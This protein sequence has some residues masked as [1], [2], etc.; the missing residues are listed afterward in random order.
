M[1]IHS[2]SLTAAGSQV[3]IPS[4]VLSSFLAW[5]C[6]REVKGQLLNGTTESLK[7]EENFEYFLSC[8]KDELHSGKEVQDH[9]QKKN[10]EEMLSLSFGV[11]AALKLFI[12]SFHNDTGSLKC[13]YYCWKCWAWTWEMWDNGGTTEQKLWMLTPS[14]LPKLVMNN[15][16][17]APALFL[18][19]WR[20][21]NEFSA[22]VVSENIC[23]QLSFHG[24]EWENLKSAIKVKL[25][26]ISLW[27]GCCQA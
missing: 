24:V 9:Q 26:P 5:L 16:R 23:C 18:P 2:P 6:P 19:M 22:N 20:D 25:L 17:I 21:L 13:F 15:V 10:M 12:L 4:P 8:Q 14:E 11:Q 3:A 7:S 1:D 27:D